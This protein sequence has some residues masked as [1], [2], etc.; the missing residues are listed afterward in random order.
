MEASSIILRIVFCGDGDRLVLAI[1]Q[2]TKRF[3]KC[4]SSVL[5]LK[6]LEL[7]KLKSR[8]YHK[9]Y[10]ISIFKIKMSER[11]SLSQQLPPICCFFPFSGCEL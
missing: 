9:G 5:N 11:T 3:M 2:K 6:I 8:E 7:I 4:P 1:M 10:N